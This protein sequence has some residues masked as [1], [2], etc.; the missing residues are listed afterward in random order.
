MNNNFS[1]KMLVFGLVFLFIGASIISKISGNTIF[2]KDETNQKIFY[3]DDRKNDGIELD[4]DFMWNVTEELC[5]VIHNSSVYPSGT[6][7]KG[8]AFGSDGDRWAA[9]YINRTMND[10]LNLEN[11]GKL[12]IESIDD[13]KLWRYNYIIEAIDFDLRINGDSYP[14]DHNMPKNEAFAW[15]SGLKNWRPGSRNFGKI[16]YNNTFTNMKVVPKN[17]IDL[18]YTSE[19]YINLELTDDT[20]NSDIIG[21]ITYIASNENIP[22]QQKGQIFLLD[23]NND[24]VYN[25]LDNIKDASIILINNDRSEKS[26]YSTD[27]INRDLII[28]KVNKS[29]YNLTKIIDILQNGIPM[30]VDN[31]NDL[32]TLTFTYNLEGKNWPDYDFLYLHDFKD[33]GIKKP[34]EN[35]LKLNWY[36]YLKSLNNKGWCYGIIAYDLHNE[37]HKMDATFRFWNGFDYSTPLDLIGHSPWLQILSINKSVGV[38]LENHYN[39]QNTRITGYFEQAEN[40]V[41]AYNVIGNITNKKNSDDE[42]VVISNR[43][44]GWWGECPGD[45]G[46][47]GGIVL[48][49]AKYFKDYNIEPKYNLNFLMTTGEEYCYRGA[50]HFT[51]SH[52]ESQYKLIQWIGAD[53]LG[54]IPTGPSSSLNARLRDNQTNAAIIREIARD[55]DY[56]NKTGYAFTTEEAGDKDGTDDYA[57][58]ATRDTDTICFHKT[59]PWD[60]HHRAGMNYKEGDSLKNMDRNDANVTFELIWNVIKYFTVNPNC[61]FENDNFALVDS[62]YDEDNLEDSINV[63]FSVKTCLPNDRIMVKASLIKAGT[64]KI[65]ANNRVNYIVTPSGIHDT[66]TLTIP[67]DEEAGWYSFRLYLYNSTGR[68]NEILNLVTKSDKWNDTNPDI[69]LDQIFYLYPNETRKVCLN[70]HSICLL[71]KPVFAKLL[72]LKSYKI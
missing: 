63:S 13:Y 55:I 30:V 14:Y 23:E 64:G 9:D 41:D 21:Y 43:Y 24:I 12:K 2:F 40:W 56:E 28:G 18:T 15:P 59:S 37:T 57:I 19:S 29:N 36:W 49:I 25:Q 50:W 65:V 70:L 35:L 20:I 68:I 7:R 60:F 10:D 44:D 34:A 51:H 46:L 62:S 17:Q 22:E 1:R 71:K 6:L 8:R 26:S 72:P 31:F 32:K 54:F 5:N 58:R 45:S 42:I 16:N 66:I 61:W 48:A 11:V 38:W 3:F 69:G 53:Q 33:G 39:E 52:P 27:L 47:G 4:Y 67:E